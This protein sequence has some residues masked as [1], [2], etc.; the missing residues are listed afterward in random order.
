[1]NKNQKNNNTGKCEQTKFG[2]PVL[3]K[4]VPYPLAS[5]QFNYAGLSP[6]FSRGTLPTFAALSPYKTTKYEL[7]FRQHFFLAPSAKNW[8]NSLRDR[9]E[10]ADRCASLKSWKLLRS[11][12][13]LYE[14]CSET[15]RVK[16]K[17][18]YRIK[19]ISKT[20]PIMQRDNLFDL[21]I[22]RDY[23]WSN[24]SR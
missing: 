9:A 14:K 11:I 4:C 15:A 23:I 24:W 3:V 5:E 7:L 8:E 18:L 12:K 19:Y 17:Y 6:H 22:P 20:N 13:F 2:Q 1:M 16:S 21:T 10:R